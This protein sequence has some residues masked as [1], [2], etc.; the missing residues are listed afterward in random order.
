ML[1]TEPEWDNI[2]RHR[3]VQQPTVCLDDASAP[4]EA[5]YR[6]L[7]N[8][9][10]ALKEAYAHLQEVDHLR[11]DL[12]DMIIHDLKNPLTIILG[13]LEVIA[14]SLGDGANQQV[15]DLIR[16]ANRSGQ[17]MLQLVVDLLEVQHLESGSM[18]VHLQPLDIAVV[19]R[20]AASQAHFLAA[21]KGL[22]LCVHVPDDLPWAWG[23]VGLISRVM[24]NLLD[25]AIR[26]S[27]Q[28]Q[29]VVV[30]SHATQREL[31][32]S[33]SN[34]GSSIPAGQQERVF[35][36][37]FQAGKGPGHERGNVGLGLAFCKLA[38]EAQRGHVWVES[39]EGAG[40]RFSFT[41]PLWERDRV[42]P[43]PSSSHAV[44]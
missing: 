7:Q 19:L 24:T 5:E 4:L 32:V 10:A 9:Y 34:S 36:K 33:V 41:L 35:D 22:D 29:A 2:R 39:Q 37:F 14:E 3:R 30:T 12:V 1:G 38:V 42:R 15:R 20:T 6:G 23:D 44:E 25:N 17:E 40:V 28:K 31:I 18:P 11:Q 43:V 8:E 13:S 27:S 26:F 16:I 21:Q